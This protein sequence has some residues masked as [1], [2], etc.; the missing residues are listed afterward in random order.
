LCGCYFH[1]RY[2]PWFLPPDSKARYETGKGEGVTEGTSRWKMK[3]KGNGKDEKILY[4]EGKVEIFCC[5][6]EL[7]VT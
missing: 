2:P 4:T 3:Q 5:W 6:Q 7:A 1:T